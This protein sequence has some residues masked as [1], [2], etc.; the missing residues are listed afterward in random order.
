MRRW[1]VVVVALAVAVLAGTV[2]HVWRTAEP[3]ATRHRPV[4]IRLLG[5]GGDPLVI[6]IGIEWPADGWCSGQ[7]TV[8][9]TETSS[10]VRVS[11]VVSR[12]PRGDGGCAA[13]GTYRGMA[14]VGLAMAAPLGTRTAVRA[15]GG[16]ALPVMA[17]GP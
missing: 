6:M 11:D 13:L 3:A 4:A 12:T 5:E 16:D 7:L 10:E 1:K 2:V 8:T 15:A 9:A 17:S 14:W